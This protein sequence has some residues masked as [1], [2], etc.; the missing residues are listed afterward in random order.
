MSFRYTSLVDEHIAAVASSLNDDSTLVRMHALMA[1]THL[2][3]ESYLRWEGQVI[4]SYGKGSFIAENLKCT[5]VACFELS[6]YAYENFA[7][8]VKDVAD[9]VQIC[10]SSSG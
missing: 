9:N 4:F 2:I 6:P 8:F 7:N 10:L 3:R 5:A 1:I